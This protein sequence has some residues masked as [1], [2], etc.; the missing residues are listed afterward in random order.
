MSLKILLQELRTA[1]QNPYVTISL[2]TQRTPPGNTKDGILL[3]NLI[4]EPKGRGNKEFDQREIRALLAEW[5]QYK[6]K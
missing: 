6:T 4:N 2:N 5:K 3:K 1:E